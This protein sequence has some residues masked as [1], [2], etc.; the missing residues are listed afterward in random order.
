MISIKFGNALT[1]IASFPLS[2]KL[3]NQDPFADKKIPLWKHLLG[4]A[5]VLLVVVAVLWF[6]KVFTIPGIES[7]YDPA[8]L[9]KV[10]A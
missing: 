7:P 5:I 4:W 1:D 2:A 6:F 8:A 3:R 10:E 9:T